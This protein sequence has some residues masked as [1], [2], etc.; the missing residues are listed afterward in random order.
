MTNV[1]TTDQYANQILT[2]LRLQNPS[3]SGEVGTPERAI[4]DVIAQ[5]L[6]ENQVNVS[7]IT[8]NFSI[9]T[10]FGAA[11]DQFTSSLGMLRQ[12]ASAA[13]G[14][15]IFSNGNTPATSTI[16]IPVGTVVQT[17][18][19]NDG[20]TSAVQFVTTTTGTIE[21]GS[22]QSNPVAI[23]CIIAGSFGNVAANTINQIL[24]TSAASLPPAI[25]VTNPNA[26]TNG[27]DAEDDNS[28]KTRFTNTWG[29]NLAGTNDQYIALCVGSPYTTKARVFGFMTPYQE[30]IRIPDYPDT[31]AT[32]TFTNG[33]NGNQWTANLS[34]NL[35]ATY[36]FRPLSQIVMQ[37]ATGP[38]PAIGP[39]AP[40]Y[41]TT[42]SYNSPQGFLRDSIDFYFNPNPYFAG[43][44]A[45]NVL[46]QVTEVVTF[47]NG[48][49][50]SLPVQ[51][52]VGNTPAQSFGQSGT[53]VIFDSGT[54]RPYYASYNGIT[55]NALL[56]VQIIYPLS[57]ANS[58][59]SL[60]TSTVTVFYIPNIAN[61]A[62]PNVT[63]NNVWNQDIGAPA[64]ALR[65]GQML[66]LEYYYI[67]SS[68]RN[69]V[70]VVNQNF[71]VIDN[72]VDIYVNGSNPQPGTSTISTQQGSNGGFLQ[73]Q[74]SNSSTTPFL[75]VQNFRRD[76]QPTVMP[77]PNNYWV[78]LFE[79]PLISI[80]ETFTINGN[81]YYL[82]THYFLVHDV[83][84]LK[85]ST[86]ARDGLEIVPDLG[87]SSSP[88]IATQPYEPTGP[89]LNFNN[90]AN[91]SFNIDYQ[92]D[93]NIPTL[94]AV[95][96]K[97]R[98]VTVDALVH[99]APTRYIKLD[100]T[101]NFQQNANIPSVISNIQL[102]VQNYLQSL[103]FGDTVSLA[104]LLSAI[105]S[106]G[107]V[108]SA[109]WSSDLNYNFNT[110][111][112]TPAL[113]VMETD[114]NGNPLHGAYAYRI[115]WNPNGMQD[116]LQI[117]GNPNG[118][119]PNNPYA[120]QNSALGDI[121]VYQ[122][123]FSI[124]WTDT[125]QLPAPYNTFS[126]QNIPFYDP[127]LFTPISPT[128][129]QES[130]FAGQT[131]PPEP[132]GSIT[133]SEYN[134]FPNIIQYLIQYGA[135]TPVLPTVSNWVTSSNLAWENDFPLRDNELVSLPIGQLSTDAAPGLIIRQG[136]NS[137]NQ[138]LLEYNLTNTGVQTYAL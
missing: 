2:A 109:Q 60:T 118:L 114:I 136:S 91:L 50:D 137:N 95:V 79:T 49:V 107:G 106:V 98:P 28:L 35:N 112:A 85:G 84:N 124:S 44:A 55:A 15:V 46:T 36:V 72:A 83:T 92:Y 70:N 3:I 102:T 89:T 101:V 14:F 53:I 10:K 75:N 21:I 122:D 133:I 110:N 5:I 125:V 82:G 117:V 87:A 40:V 6:A 65:P 71:S 23:Q 34:S 90:Y 45:R 63:F 25:T 132:Y 76:Q 74:S 29:R 113:K 127:K 62:P 94:Q 116:I 100:V 20:S 69:A 96:D 8:S 33:L 12:S 111:L 24:T 17:S 128:I 105:T 129:I 43:D 26:I 67:S 30:L 54:Y 22:I 32:S 138:K 93:A 61:N 38:V 108:Q 11:L 86:R 42:G 104:A 41:I 58:T 103:N 27:T 131:T 18:V 47:Q 130:I 120:S 51:S 78:P 99:Q 135:G 115:N 56:N 1:L 73:F 59:F 16:S 123:W 88:P 126:S 64:D 37:T 4:I 119:T 134:T 97:A 68:S 57:E 80:P 52:T 13:T 48:F 66:A 31:G 81:N 121:L 77:S 7:G 39:T 19:T 9:D